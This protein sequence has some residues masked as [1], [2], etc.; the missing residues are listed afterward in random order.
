MGREAR[1]IAKS[2]W[3]RPGWLLATGAGLIGLVGVSVWLSMPKP[4]GDPKGVVIGQLIPAARVLPKGAQR[5]YLWKLEPRWD[6]CDGRSGTFGWSGVAV[7]SGFRWNGA[8]DALFSSLSP[9]LGALGWI[10]SGRAWGT[11]PAEQMWTK[12]LTSGK[13]ATLA[14]TR[15][16]GHW[17]LDAQAAPAGTAAKGC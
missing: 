1:E 11:K 12:T 3:C 10:R 14:V 15:E 13:T 2:H 5:M 17:Q 7:Q 16:G 4:T 9:R 8:P 6:S